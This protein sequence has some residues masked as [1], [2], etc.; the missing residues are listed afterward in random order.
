MDSEEYILALASI[1]HDIGKIEQR[2]DFQR[3]RGKKHAEIGAEFIR[4]YISKINNNVREKIISLVKYHHTTKPELDETMAYLLGILKEADWKS[5]AHDREDNDPDEFKDIKLHKITDS[6][7]FEDNEK[8]SSSPFELKTLEDYQDVSKDLGYPSLLGTIRCDISRIDFNDMDKSI[9]VLDSVLF[10]DTVFV[11]SAFWY[12]KPDISL[13]HHLKLTAALATSIYRYEKQ[14]RNLANTREKNKSFLLLMCNV[15]GI[16]K[17]IFRHYRTDSADEKGMNR[18]KGRSFMIKLFTDSIETYIL[19][20]FGLHRFNI[21]WEKSDGF[22]MLLDNSEGM[23][24]NLKQIR[25]EIDIGLFEKKRG[26]SATIAWTDLS[27][28]DFNTLD[29]SN[30]KDNFGLIMQNLYNELDRAKRNKYAEIIKPEYYDIIFGNSIQ[31][32]CESCGL[33]T[34]EK[35]KER[36]SGCLEEENAGKELYK[37]AYILQRVGLENE[38]GSIN[39]RYGEYY[40]IYKFKEGIPES[41]PEP[42]YD[43]TITI[44]DFKF[45][46]YKSWRFMM[47]ATNAKVENGK[48]VPINDLFKVN[49]E[50]KMFSVFK[51]DVDN[52]GA[53]VSTGFQYLTISRLSQLSFQFEYFFSIELDKIAAKDDIY[54]IYSGGDDVSAMGRA[55]SMASFIKKFKESFDSYFSNSSITISA[56]INLISPKFPLRRAISNADISVERA[57]KGGKNRIDFINTMDWNKFLESMELGDTIYSIIKENKLSKGFPY[58]L[59]NLGKQYNKKFKKG[60]EISIPDPMV[61]YYINR[62]YR[63]RDESE[64]KTLICKLL[65]YDDNYKYYKYW[66]NMDFLT[67]YIV[68]KGRGNEWH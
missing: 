67:S 28:D 43:T 35:N 9:Q 38:P 58:F 19:K 14:D 41:V 7:G 59:F 11:P 53:I 25:N 47:Q 40:I 18:L 54:I 42:G 26:V 64:K 5:A 12:S 63:S 22:L 66:G 4:N 1:L 21:V 16:Q 10:K 23:E 52:M 33:D 56:G 2:A 15:S 60:A 34:I 57:K 45:R 68:I 17:Y 44:N 49:E 46:D 36:C 32:M 13:Y 20:K 51:A 27:L 3:N 31:D 55:A 24:N 65:Q 29:K 8:A 6:I 37:K 39:F 62:N 61:E 50:H 30:K 48:V